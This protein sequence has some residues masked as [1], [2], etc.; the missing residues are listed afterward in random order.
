MIW[1][2]T[3]R[4]DTHIHPRSSVA[5]QDPF[6][7]SVLRKQ[8]HLPVWTRASMA[9]SVKLPSAEQFH[10][11]VTAPV[12]KRDPLLRTPDCEDRSEYALGAVLTSGACFPR[13]PS[14]DRVQHP[15]SPPLRDEAVIRL[16]D[17][18]FI[19]STPDSALPPRISLPR[20]DCSL[21]SSF[22]SHKAPAE[23]PG[24][25]AMLPAAAVGRCARRLPQLS[26]TR[27][28]P[29]HA[30]RPGWVAVGSPLPD[31]DLVEHSPGNKVNL[32]DEIKGKG[33]II[34]VPAAF[35]MSA[36]SLPLVPSSPHFP[37]LSVRLRFSCGLRP[38]MGLALSPS[39]PQA[40]R[41][42]ASATG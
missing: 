8:F 9:R 40:V 11:C 33:L 28:R 27:H 41:T 14:P 2:G 13:S 30:S 19:L 3:V 15:P 10:A 32:F 36:L 18:I 35:S 5:R 12:M 22:S 31:V 4:Y 24:T 20:G 42:T 39:L 34:G 38:S 16:I 29:F 7:Y 17:A 37:M 1:S 26:P 21:L 25:R 23:D 6:P